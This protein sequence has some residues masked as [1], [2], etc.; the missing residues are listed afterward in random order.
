MLFAGKPLA[1]VKEVNARPPGESSLPN[2][3][4]S[5]TGLGLHADVAFASIAASES[6]VRD[7]SAIR[8]SQV[9]GDAMP[10]DA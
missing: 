7:A 1:N 8:Q 9:S 10:V 3:V 5:R 2:C 6:E 4:S